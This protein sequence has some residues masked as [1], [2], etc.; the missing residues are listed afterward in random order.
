MQGS[1]KL[2]EIRGG[3]AIVAKDAHGTELHGCTDVVAPHL[4]VLWVWETGT[5][6]RRLLN[7]ADFDFDILPRAADATPLRL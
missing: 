5:G 6:T 4:G 1:Q 7:A 3:D 2:H